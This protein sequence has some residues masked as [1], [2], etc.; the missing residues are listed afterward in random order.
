MLALVTGAT[1]FI[2]GRLA[3]ASRERGWQVRNLHRTGRAPGTLVGLGAEPVAASLHDSAALAAACRGCDVVFHAAAVVGSRAIPPAVFEVNVRGTEAMLRAASAAGV[4]RFVFT[5]SVAVYGGSAPD[6][7][8][9]DAP[10]TPDSP[11]GESKVAAERLCLEESRRTG[12]EVVILR[13]CFVYGPGDRNFTPAL[14]SIIKRGVF[15][16]V[17]GGRAPMDL[18]HVDDVVAAHLLAADSPHASRRAYN[19]TDGARRSIRDL[20]ALAAHVMGVRVRAIPVPLGL[21]LLAAALLRAAASLVGV[22]GSE[23]V[24]AANLR[25]LGAPHHYSIARARAELGYEPRWQAE[26]VLDSVLAPYG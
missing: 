21:A 23:M 4:G 26:D 22:P 18:V 19:V 5:S 13:P 20:V 9:E 14:A 2:G 6:G 12:I 17:N 15:P 8:T 10:P 25:R 11:Y 3:A 24:T 7:A 16:L 1:G